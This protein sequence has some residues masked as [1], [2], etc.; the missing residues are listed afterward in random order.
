M[1]LGLMQ[2]RL[3]PPVGDTIQRFPGQQWR[4]EF[5]SAAELG[6]DTIEWIV[7]GATDNP[8]ADGDLG[9][10]EGAMEDTGVVVSSVCADVFMEEHRLAHGPEDSRA[11]AVRQL[12][13][14]LRTCGALG[15]T[16]IVLPFVD[17]SELTDADDLVAATAVIEE[18]LPVAHSESVE[19]HLETSLAPSDFASFLAGLPDPMVK[20]NYDM[21][22]SAALGYRPAEE[23]A[24]YGSRLGSVH[25]KDR[26]LGGTT[27]ALGTGSTDF[28][29]VSSGLAQLDYD[30][31]YILQVARG[32]SGDEV[33][34]IRQAV[35]F[36]RDR[37]FDVPGPSPD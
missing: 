6:L 21:G 18:V 4:Q 3:L 10:V 36:A 9:P 7:D 20:V 11:M 22:N 13:Q 1:R 19:L 35:K 14:L 28:D 25:I 17:R 31:D 15:A 27:V 23:F 12:V 34:N 37:I 5:I 8:L 33:E 24:A 32:Q 29:A 30:G 26:V 2:G 16:R